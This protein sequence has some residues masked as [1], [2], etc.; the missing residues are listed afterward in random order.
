MHVQDEEGYTP[1]CAAAE[2]GHA[3]AVQVRPFNQAT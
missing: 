1:L 3:D 2:E